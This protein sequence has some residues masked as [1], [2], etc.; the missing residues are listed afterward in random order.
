M[1]PDVDRLIHTYAVVSVCRGK[2]IITEDGEVWWMYLW[3]LY[4]CLCHDVCFYRRESL[5][6]KLNYM[7]DELQECQ[8]TDP[9]WLSITGKRGKEG[10]LQLLQRECGV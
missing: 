7:L 6:D 4:V 9:G 8:K 1:S 2:E 5:L 10:Y 3:S